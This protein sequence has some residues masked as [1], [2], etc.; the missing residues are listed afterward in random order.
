M[1]EQ[2]NPYAA[3]DH[4]A[5][6][7]R[8]NAEALWA[9]L[10][11]LPALAH[12]ERHGGFYVVTRHS[13]L[14]AAAA[15]HAIYSSAFGVALPS[16]DRTP[17]I[18][19]EVDP[20]LQREY[21]KILD[22]F[23][24]RG[25]V[26]QFEPIVARHALALL[27]SFADEREVDFVARFSRPFPV[28]ASI[29]SFGFPPGDGE[30]LL[31]L[32]TGL[33]AN[34]G[35]EA[36]KRASQDLTAYILNLLAAKAARPDADIVTAIAQGSVAGRALTQAEQVSMT[37]L[38]LFGGFTTVDLALSCA[39]Y[40]F[41]KQPALLRRLHEA[42]D[43][44]ATAVEEIVRIASPATYL[45]RTVTCPAQLGGAALQQG[46]RI[47]LCFAA[48]NRDP[49]MFEHPLDVQLDRNPNPHVAFGFG[50]HRCVGS[51]FAKLEMR[52]ALAELA[53]RYERFEL[54]DEDTLAWGQGETQGFAQL[55]LKLHPRRTA[56]R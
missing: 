33:I 2:A 48:A 30:Q 42:P 7:H 23:L 39:A 50:T 1:S 24:A 55:P 12:S 18:P 51:M 37:R 46:D 45:A 54:V 38:L 47:L 16:E 5:P 34:R 3:F 21:R 15:Q 29:E 9:E 22:P 31:G 41:A 26:D 13:D 4:H 10:R 11:A 49:E 56:T 43:L 6:N 52:V 25:V 32:V 53:R 44:M 8:K 28:L 40:L 20:P 14:R 35:N 36:G 19:E 27:D 17:H